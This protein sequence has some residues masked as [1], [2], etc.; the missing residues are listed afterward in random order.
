MICRGI[1]GAALRGRVAKNMKL[2][3]VK[4][5]DAREEVKWRLDTKKKMNLS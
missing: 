1:A 5:R 4:E 2:V 3:E